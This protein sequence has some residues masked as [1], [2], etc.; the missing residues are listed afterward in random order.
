[1]QENEKNF[2]YGAENVFPYQEL[3][4]LFFF[5]AG[6][7]FFLYYSDPFPY[8][9]GF[10]DSGYL[11]DI[12]N[13][14]WFFKEFSGDDSR[15]ADILGVFVVNVS[16]SFLLTLLGIITSLVWEALMKIYSPEKRLMKVYYY[17]LPCFNLNKH[18]SISPYIVLE[19]LIVISFFFM[20]PLIIIDTYSEKSL[21]HFNYDLFSVYIGMVAFA[22]FSVCLQAICSALNRNITFS[23][24]WSKS[25]F[26]R[27][28]KMYCFL[29]GFAVL[30]LS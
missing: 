12:L 1:M 8:L 30:S 3:P 17:L 6:L 15:K 5:I 18:L 2:V 13:R 23:R 7:A 11:R 16:F 9:N 10:P 22:I 14:C 27:R 20:S 26:L 29:V 19:F 24:N 28:I 21:R 25:Q 4:L